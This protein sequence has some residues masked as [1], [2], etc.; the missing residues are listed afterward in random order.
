MQILGILMFF[1]SKLGRLSFCNIMQDTLNSLII[2]EGTM[3]DNELSA[4]ILASGKSRRFG[5]QKVFAL[6]AGKPLLQSAIELGQS[7]SPNLMII[8]N[9]L[10]SKSGFPIVQYRDLYSNKGPLA[11]IHSALYHSKSN[12]TAILPVDMPFLNLEIYQCLW[13]FR[14][15]ERPVVAESDTGM[16]PLVSIWPGQSI[17]QIE[18]FL[19]NDQLG[20]YQCLL[21]MRADC[22][23]IPGEL[24]AY[25]EKFFLNINRETDLLK[26]GNM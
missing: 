13:S 22:I 9:E 24:P 4:A 2:Q 19:K 25:E 20:I 17:K 1:F 26:A 21:D 10:I 12:W 16:E 18:R 23:N 11:G 5:R 14:S 7:L 8:G 15:Q 6:L 3:I